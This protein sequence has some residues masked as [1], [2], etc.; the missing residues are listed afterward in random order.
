LLKFN[1]GARDFPVM[2]V[3]QTKVPAAFAKIDLLEPEIWFVFQLTPFA[4]LF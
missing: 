4:A 1:N 3:I 2:V